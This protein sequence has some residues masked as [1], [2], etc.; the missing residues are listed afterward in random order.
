LAVTN[1]VL[2][3]LVKNISNAMERLNSYSK[4][5]AVMCMFCWLAPLKYF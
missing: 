5:Q 4:K 3:V 1:C 2:V